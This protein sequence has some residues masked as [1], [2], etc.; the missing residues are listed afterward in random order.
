MLEIDDIGICSLPKLIM[1][2]WHMMA[3]DV[4]GHFPIHVSIQTRLESPKVLT[5]DHQR[6]SRSTGRIWILRRSS[7]VVVKTGGVRVQGC[8]IRLPHG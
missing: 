7:A 6:G 5:S 3:P 8:P 2:T 1:A 4:D